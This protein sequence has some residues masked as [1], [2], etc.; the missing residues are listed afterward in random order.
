MKAHWT[1][2]VAVLLGA[3]VLGVALTGCSKE[4]NRYLTTAPDTR[5][6]SD[7]W[8]T[9]QVEPATYGGVCPAAFDFS[10]H[11]S[12]DAA[13]EVRY[14]WEGSDG[15]VGAEQGLSFSGAGTET[16]Y[17]RRSMVRGGTFT[18]RV[19]ILAPRDTFSA[20]VS[21]TNACEAAAVEATA[22]WKAVFDWG[23]PC[24]VSYDLLGQITTNAST[25]TYQWEYSDGGVGPVETLSFGVPGTQ[26]F[27]NS[28]HPSTESGWARLHVLT[29]ID[30]TSN[31]A[32][33]TYTTPCEE[34]RGTEK[35]AQLLRRA[36][37]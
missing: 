24:S 9:A 17:L 37:N 10:A 26:T 35:G 21:F 6:Q 13:T 2:Y 4:R 1:V 20:P 3:A 7:V 22:W 31:L 32:E 34:S 25:V 27:R 12:T 18:E 23:D 8:A 15:H 5:L 36:R 30:V 16:V 11:V 33:I 19:H 29:P 28:W 14:R